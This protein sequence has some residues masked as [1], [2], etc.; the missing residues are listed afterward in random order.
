MKR[1]GYK[2]K[3]M[4]VIELNEAFAAQSLGV[5]KSLAEEHDIGFDELLAKTNLQ[6]GAI[7]LG[8]PVGASGARISVTL[9]HIMQRHDFKLGLASLCIGGGM[10]TAVIFKKI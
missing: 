1:S 8:H 4:D 6:G 7:A 5:L 10:G 9:L 3:D 2:L